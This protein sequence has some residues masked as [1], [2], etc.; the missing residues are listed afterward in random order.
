MAVLST[1]TKLAG[2]VAL[3]SLFLLAVDFHN[4]TVVH[5]VV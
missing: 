2:A 4:L 3:T 1:V 5:A